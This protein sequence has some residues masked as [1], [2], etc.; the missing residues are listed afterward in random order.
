MLVLT[1]KPGEEIVFGDA[2]TGFGIKVIVL[3][4]RGDKIR[5]GIDAP[6][7]TVVLRGELLPKYLAQKEQSC[8]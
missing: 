6:A 7:D 1:R 8:S 2:A 4:I 5:L 3:E